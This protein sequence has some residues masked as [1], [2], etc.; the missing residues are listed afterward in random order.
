MFMQ[1]LEL[2]RWAALAFIVFFDAIG[3]LALALVLVMIAVGMNWR[4]RRRGEAA[5]SIDEFLAEL[6]RAFNEGNAALRAWLDRQ[7]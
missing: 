6:D 5:R 4:R 3:L 1:I 7:R 2:I